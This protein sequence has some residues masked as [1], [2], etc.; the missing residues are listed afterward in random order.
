MRRS[1]GARRKRKSAT[2]NL[3][4]TQRTGRVPVLFGQ[5]FHHPPVLCHV[6]LRP[7]CQWL[8]YLTPKDTTGRYQK[9][10]PESVQA[11]LW[12]TNG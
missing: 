3:L 2:D 10:I 1:T 7:G 9:S 11:L 5:T 8:D 12:F 4:P 6:R